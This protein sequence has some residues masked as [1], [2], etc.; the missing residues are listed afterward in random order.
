MSLNREGIWDEVR[1]LAM[2]SGMSE[3]EAQGLRS[4][5]VK[6]SRTIFYGQAFHDDNSRG[7]DAHRHTGIQVLEG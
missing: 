7:F 6:R 1:T 2:A 5:G 4:P 3:V